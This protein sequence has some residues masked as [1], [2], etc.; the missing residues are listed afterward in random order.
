MRTKEQMANK[1]MDLGFSPAYFGFRAILEL[2]EVWKPSE[3]ITACYAIVGKKLGIT[4]YQV[5]R[6]IR[7]SIEVAMLYNQ[8]GMK[9]F[10]RNS[11]DSHKPT[12]TEFMA[13]LNLYYEEILS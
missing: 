12:I 6:N 2:A 3:K 10:L 4:Q 7:H 11:Y 1:L 8:D 13:V 9:N 5:E